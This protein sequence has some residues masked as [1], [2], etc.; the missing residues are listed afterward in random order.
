MFSILMLVFMVASAV[1]SFMGMKAL[2]VAQKHGAAL[3]VVAIVGAAFVVATYLARSIPGEEVVYA[4]AFA[5]LICI[6]SLIGLA[7][8]ALLGWLIVR[9]RQ[10]R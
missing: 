6:P 5:F 7:A 2:M 4:V 1:L 10:K 9:R 8:G 3:S